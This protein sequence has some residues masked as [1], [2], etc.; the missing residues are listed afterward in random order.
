MKPTGDWDGAYLSGL[1]QMGLQEGLAL[2]YKASAALACA[3]HGPGEGFSQPDHSLTSRLA[4][5]FR[6][7][8]DNHGSLI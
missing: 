7:N 5:S 1:I 3:E 2:D 8:H 4:R 6:G